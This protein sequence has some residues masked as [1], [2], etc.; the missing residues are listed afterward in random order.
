[1]SVTLYHNPQ[2]SKCREVL[3]L[4]RSR[5]VEPRLVEYLKTPPDRQTLTA[6]LA[7]LGMEPRE[8]MR[9]KEAA[10]KENNL[11]DPD[12]TREALIDA[13]VSHPRLI[14]RPIAMTDKKAVVGRPPE[15]VLEL[16]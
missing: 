7:L 13:M 1:M 8:L 10:Y 12:L 14:E 2:C 15:K 5:G 9:T 4:L 3:A 16:L 11:H 6:I